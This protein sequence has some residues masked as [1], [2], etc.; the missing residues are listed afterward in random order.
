MAGTRRPYHLFLEVSHIRSGF[1]EYVAD[2][3]RTV[4]QNVNKISTLSREAKREKKSAVTEWASV[5]GRL[6]SEFLLGCSVT[7]TGLLL[8]N[9]R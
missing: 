9:E 8:G 7:R 1:L 3:A 2:R 6:N 4:R 5:L